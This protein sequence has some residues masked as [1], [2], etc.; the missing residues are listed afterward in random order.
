MPINLTG[1]DQSNKI[2]LKGKTDCNIKPSYKINQLKTYILANYIIP[3]YSE[4]WQIIHNNKILI[5]G[6]IKQVTNYY[7]L[8]K[9]EEL[10]LFLEL[11]K[12]LKI[13]IT[14][15]DILTDLENKTQKIYDKN[16]IINMVY[17]TTRIQILP[18]YELYNSILG[19]P[20]KLNPY[21]DD[22]LNEIRILILKPNITYDKISC[23][24]K[25]KYM[26]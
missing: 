9:L 24:I 21:N 16:N 13:L 2:N 17:K 23:F 5:D 25:E 3:L 20:T 22:I 18:E 8:Y 19:K 11:L 15:N 6:T 4:Q 10:S 26:V 1:S 12:V 7:K 14:K